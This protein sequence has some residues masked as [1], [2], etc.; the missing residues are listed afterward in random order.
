MDPESKIAVTWTYAIGQEKFRVHLTWSFNSG[1]QVVLVNGLEEYYHIAK[2]A[3]KLDIK[4]PTPKQDIWIVAVKSK[5]VHMHS[6]RRFE[7]VVNGKTFHSFARPGKPKDGRQSLHYMGGGGPQSA[8]ELLYP[9]KAKEIANNTGMQ[10]P[11]GRSQ[12]VQ[13]QPMVTQPAA[14]TAPQVVEG[15]LISFD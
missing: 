15:D 5:P 3:N 6:F 7:L 10:M 2:G 8:L 13:Q 9:E 1:K 12:Y 11:Q 4:V 14:Q